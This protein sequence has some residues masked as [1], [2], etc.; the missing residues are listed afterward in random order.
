MWWVV[1]ARKRCRPTHLKLGELLMRQACGTK[2]ALV[3]AKF[4][5]AR[6]RVCECAVERAR[7]CVGEKTHCH[8]AC[9]SA[10]ARVHGAPRARLP[11]AD[12]LRTISV[13]QKLLD[14]GRARRVVDEDLAD[15]G[16]EVDLL[17]KV[18]AKGARTRRHPV[19]LHFK[20]VSFS[21]AEVHIFIRRRAKS[22]KQARFRMRGVFGA[23]PHGRHSHL[24]PRVTGSSASFEALTTPVTD[25]TSPSEHMVHSEHT[26]YCISCTNP[27][28]PAWTGA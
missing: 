24:V 3:D 16:G 20:T 26:V 1:C 25:V 4:D 5:G 8:D 10:S 19:M 23:S 28:T 18:V 15:A 11:P 2:R 22:G 7:V 12:A 21:S 14:D 13:L 9:T 27:R 6:A 17:P